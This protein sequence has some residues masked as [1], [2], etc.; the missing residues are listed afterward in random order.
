VDG[1]L[2]AAPSSNQVTILLQ[3]GGHHLE[4]DWGA[5]RRRDLGAEAGQQL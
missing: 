3:E 2:G 4:F 5:G 1:T